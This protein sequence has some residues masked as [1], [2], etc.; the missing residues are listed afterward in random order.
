MVVRRESVL[1]GAS[2]SLGSRGVNLGEFECRQW[3][4]RGS[5]SRTEEEWRGEEGRDRTGQVVWA[6]DICVLREICEPAID[7]YYQSRAN[8]LA[9]GKSMKRARNLC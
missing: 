9:L 7:R 4:T 8:R 5:C 2:S 1:D 3:I 6:A